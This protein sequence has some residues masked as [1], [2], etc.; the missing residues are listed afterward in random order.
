M[1]KQPQKNVQVDFPTVIAIACLLKQGGPAQTLWDT[2]TEL[3]LLCIQEGGAWISEEGQKQL[4]YELLSQLFTIDRAPS[5]SFVR[6]R[7]IWTLKN[8]F[9]SGRAFPR[10]EILL[11]IITEKIEY[12]SFDYKYILP[13]RIKPYQ[14]KKKTLLLERKLLSLKKWKPG[15]M[16][17]KKLNKKQIGRSQIYKDQ[18]KKLKTTQKIEI[19]NNTSVTNEKLKSIT[20]LKQSGTN[21]FQK[22]QNREANMR[23]VDLQELLEKLRE[24]LLRELPPIFAR[25]DIEKLLPGVISART[26]EN[27]DSMG[28]GPKSIINGKKILYIREEFVDWLISYLREKN[29]VVNRW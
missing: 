27:L 23:K 18:N 9:I 6:Q 14:P 28:K 4:K 24:N 2:V 20:L 22:I 17:K 5:P 25:K 19:L 13:I 29:K 3:A 1:K 21:N 12:F 15:A 10:P 16:T 8:L 26:L 11:P 7:L